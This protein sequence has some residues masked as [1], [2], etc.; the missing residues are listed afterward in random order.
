[1]TEGPIIV[2]W[3]GGDRGRDALALASLLARLDG[4][5]VIAAHAYYAPPPA[6]PLPDDYAN[7]LHAAAD[8]QVRGI[9]RRLLTGVSF[10]AR[11]LPGRAPARGLHELAEEEHAA[12]VVLGATHHGAIGSAILGTVADRLLHGAPCPVA[13]APPGYASKA[14]GRLGVIAVG[15]DGSR[16]SAAAV[17][18]AASWASRAGATLRIVAIIEPLGHTLLGAGASL[19]EGAMH[20]E[21]DHLRAQLREVRAALPEGL[22][23]EVDLHEG[24]PSDELLEAAKHADLLVL[25]SRDYGPVLRVVIGDASAE[26]TRKSACPVLVVQ[27]APA[28]A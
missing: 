8:A 16:D 19:L 14:P 28:A 4:S 25:G 15:F 12:L 13:I 3:D 5:E 18:A 20:V 10:E 9:P 27:R 6:H 1:M 21:R 24:D 23:V 26:V 7:A 2:G 22:T 11:Q 17:R